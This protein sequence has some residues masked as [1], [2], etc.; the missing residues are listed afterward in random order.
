MQFGIWKLWWAIGKSKEQEKVTV[1]FF[2]EKELVE[3]DYNNWQ[4][5]NIQNIIYLIHLNRI[6][7]IFEEEAR[8]QDRKA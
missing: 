2:Q 1:S 6:L 8:R 4:G 5:V 7:L 3:R